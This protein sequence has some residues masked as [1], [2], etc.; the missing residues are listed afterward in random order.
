MFQALSPV[1]KRIQS[2]TTTVSDSKL[3]SPV[4]KSLLNSSGMSLHGYVGTAQKFILDIIKIK[5][6]ETDH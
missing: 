4:N 3:F 5:T 6:E 1:T 2:K